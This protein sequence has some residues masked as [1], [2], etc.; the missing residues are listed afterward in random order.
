MSD[1]SVA[2]LGSGALWNVV[3]GKA[4]GA[5]S[6]HLRDR[7]TGPSVTI[8]VCGKPV[9]VVA[10][11]AQV[12]ES[13]SWAFPPASTF[14]FGSEFAPRALVKQ[15]LTTEGAVGRVFTWATY[16]DGADHERDQVHPRTGQDKPDHYVR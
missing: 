6:V 2:S 7:A 3:Q 9:A 10:L 4:I 16:S 8:Y 14:A 5:A 1:T 13:V 15:A 11:K 12:V